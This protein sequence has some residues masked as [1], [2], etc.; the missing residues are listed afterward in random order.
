[1][2][3]EGVTVKSYFWKSLLRNVS[4]VPRNVFKSLLSLVRVTQVTG[5][6]SHWNSLRKYFFQAF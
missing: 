2:H 4:Y 6:T 3:K 1:M 5:I